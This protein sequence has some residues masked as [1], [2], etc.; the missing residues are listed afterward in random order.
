MSGLI[1][2]HDRPYRKGVGVVL[3]NADGLA[4][5]ARR[6]DTEQPAWQFPQGGIDAGESPRQAALRELEEEIG[7]A[8]AEI[9][10]ETADWLGYDLPREVADHCWK[11]RFRGQKQKW[12]AARFTGTD[13]DID[14][15]TDH[16]EFSE[17]QWM[18]LDQVP[19]LIV[20]FKRALY[21]RVVAEFL[22]LAK[23]L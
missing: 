4:F 9:V 5:A 22:P 16:P 14:I 23:P 6:I 10:A 11:G 19:A 12:F 21:D 20:P 2:Y 17:W 8:K 13:A 1:P 7:T 18:P 3:L 15:D